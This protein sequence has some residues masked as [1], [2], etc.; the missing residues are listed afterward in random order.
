MHVRRQSKYRGSTYENAR[1]NTLLVRGRH[2]W[3]SRDIYTLIEGTALI[4]KA[5]TQGGLHGEKHLLKGH[6]LYSASTCE[7][8]QRAAFSASFPSR[9]A[10]ENR[11]SG[12]SLVLR[13]G[14][15][16]Q[17]PLSHEVPVCRYTRDTRPVPGQTR[18][19]HSSLNDGFT[20]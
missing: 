7:E 11:V 18:S 16:H 6:H 12:L 14:S 20:V 8:R 4:G 10:E 15:G 3:K 1:E 17:H 2:V 13:A 9:L 19:R 5:R